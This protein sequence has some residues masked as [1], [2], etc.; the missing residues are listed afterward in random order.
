MVDR[1]RTETK[2]SKMDMI[3][4]YKVSKLAFPISDYK[5]NVQVLM[6]VDGGRNF[7]YCGI[8]R[9]CKSKEEALIY[10]SQRIDF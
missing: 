8:G 10:V 6:S 3:K 9:Y 1:I 2:E 5:Y 4:R 7:Y